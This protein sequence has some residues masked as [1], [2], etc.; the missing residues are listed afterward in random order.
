MQLALT[1]GLGTCYGH[2][3][4]IVKWTGHGAAAARPVPP[5]GRKAAV[6]SP[7]QAMPIRLGIRSLDPQLFCCLHK[8]TNIGHN[9]PIPLKWPC[10]TG[11]PTTF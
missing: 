2:Q 3:V 4:S 11:S 8:V 10:I 9:T 6:R 1:N 7:L 5:T